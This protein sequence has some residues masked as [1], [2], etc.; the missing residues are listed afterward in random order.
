MTF[1]VPLKSTITIEKWKE[2]KVKCKLKTHI[3][4]LYN[5]RNHCPSMKI[6]KMTKQPVIFSLPTFYMQNRP[7]L[8]K[9]SLKI[10]P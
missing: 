10:Y 2:F 8:A 4:L 5:E 9:L 1:E 6:H 7:I 3:K